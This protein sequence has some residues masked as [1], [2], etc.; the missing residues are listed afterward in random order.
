MFA[1]LTTW[2]SE[3]EVA[4]LSLTLIQVCYMSLGPQGALNTTHKHAHGCSAHSFRLPAASC[5]SFCRL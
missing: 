4:E 1:P 2:L 5:I 3:P